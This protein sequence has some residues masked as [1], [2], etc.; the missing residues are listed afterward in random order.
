MSRLG[1]LESTIVTRLATAAYS[2]APLFAVV[3]GASGGD[4]P[5][6][7]AAIRRERM[8]A[9]YVGFTG[10]LTSDAAS[11]DERGPNFSVFVAARA[12]RTTSNPRA[13]DASS[14]GAFTLI[15]Q[16]TAL[17][18]GYEPNGT[19]HFEEQGIKFIDADDRV[20]IYRLSYRA[21]PPSLTAKLPGAPLNLAEA[22]SGQT[23][24][25]KFVWQPPAIGPTVDKPDF[26]RVYRKAAGDSVFK[27][28]DTAAKD[29]TSKLLT[30][31]ALGQEIPYYVTG[32][33]V[34]GE[35]PASNTLWVET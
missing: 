35:G 24:M 18:D 21:W 9:A 8:P 30:A 31:Q 12:L 23:G 7:H 1:D 25:M 2:G 26:Y 22:Q 27:L 6:L 19:T 28:L 5:A 4:R 20:A 3:R 17:L 32:V 14:L 15:D 29:P 34:A 11:F 10:E 33:N 16:V 13:G